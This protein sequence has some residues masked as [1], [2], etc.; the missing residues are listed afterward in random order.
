MAAPTAQAG[1]DL[2]RK[3]TPSGRKK[4][5]AHLAKLDEIKRV[6]AMLFY[7]NG[8]EATDVRAISDAVHLH[9]STLYT[10]IAGK[11][12]LLYLILEDGMRE[13]NAA[14]DTALNGRTEPVERLEAA[15]K[16]HVLHHAK[17]RQ[18]AWTSRIE[19][20]ALTGAYRERIVSLRDRYQARWVELVSEG[21]RAGV[22]ARHDPKIAVFMML[23]IGESVA[24]WFSPDGRLS[25]EELATS[26]ADQVLRGQL[27]SGLSMP[28]PTG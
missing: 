6:A 7:T 8:Y 12:E 1:D 25:A 10:Y 5:K 28:L 14:L 21:Q 23:G 24:G 20:R 27:V 3:T 17:R 9:V 22:L 19:I 13:I 2:V 16:A 4:T 26:I 15:I 11:E 18:V